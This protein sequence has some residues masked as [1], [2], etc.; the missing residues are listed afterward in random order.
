MKFSEAIRLGAV[1]KEQG[2]GSGHYDE[3]KSCANNAAMDA[4]GERGCG[5]LS[6]SFPVTEEPWV[7]CPACGG[8]PFAGFSSKIGGNVAHLNDVHRWSR[9]QIADWVATIEPQ[10]FTLS[11]LDI[12]ELAD[13][14]RLHADLGLTK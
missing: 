8:G 14:P 1:L 7:P 5:K 11:P 9:E 10:E 6:V 3:G 13:N 4:I 12:A 2:F